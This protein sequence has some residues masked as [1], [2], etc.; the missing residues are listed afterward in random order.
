MG[1]TPRDSDGEAGC[2]ATGLDEPAPRWLWM[3]GIADIG[4]LPGVSVLWFQEP[5]ENDDGSRTLHNQTNVVL[6]PEPG[7]SEDEEKDGSAARALRRR[8]TR[9]VRRS[10]LSLVTSGDAW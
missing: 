1:G 5:N 9:A 8:H 4:I 2:F 7:L 10:A 6:C 3:Q